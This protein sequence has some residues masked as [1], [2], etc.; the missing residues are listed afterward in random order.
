ME[1]NSL[2]NFERGPPKDHF[3]QVWLESIQWFRR[4][5][6]LKNVNGRTDDDDDDDDGRSPILIAPL[7][8]SAQVS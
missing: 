7:E 8:P 4:R 2:N 6:N 1:S 3:C 5:C